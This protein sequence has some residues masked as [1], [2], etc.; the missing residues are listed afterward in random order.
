MLACLIGPAG[1][2]EA[3]SIA[4]TRIDPLSDAEAQ[5]SYI[6]EN[7]GM[8]PLSPMGMLSDTSSSMGAENRE[9]MPDRGKR[10]VRAPEDVAQ[11]RETTGLAVLK[12]PEDGVEKMFHGARD[13]ANEAV[14]MVQE[15]CCFLGELVTVEENHTREV[16][17]LLER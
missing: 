1:T 12:L 3:L 13:E 17:R 2:L 14:R 9:A 5:L 10:A 8:P 4:L 15:I 6:R 11:A 7:A 16:L